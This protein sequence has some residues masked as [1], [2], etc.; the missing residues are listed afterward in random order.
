MRIQFLALLCAAALLASC[1]T[2]PKSPEQKADEQCRLFRGYM[3]SQE[4][5]RV[6]EAC[7]RQMGEAACRKCLYE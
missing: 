4:H 2:E 5:Y 7:T 1:S 6:M 3:N